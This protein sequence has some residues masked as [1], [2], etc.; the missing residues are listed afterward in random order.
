MALIW[1][2]RLIVQVKF[3]DSCLHGSGPD[4][5][6]SQHGER[7]ASSVISTLQ[8]APSCSP[9]SRPLSVSSPSL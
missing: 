8:A 6:Q 4:S 9:L 7:A 5:A 1:N 3:Q 2:V